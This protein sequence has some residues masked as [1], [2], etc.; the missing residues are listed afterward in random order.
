VR[1][2]IVNRLSGDIWRVFLDL[3]GRFS[4]VT[5]D[6]QWSEYRDQ[7]LNDKDIKV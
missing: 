1:L 7:T 6:K 2:K 3:R 5:S 4:F